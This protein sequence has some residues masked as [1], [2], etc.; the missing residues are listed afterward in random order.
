MLG[1]KITVNTVKNA[2]KTL[3]EDTMLSLHLQH[4][5][6]QWPRTDWSIGN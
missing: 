3:N 5:I 2:I 4:R 1:Y 6:K